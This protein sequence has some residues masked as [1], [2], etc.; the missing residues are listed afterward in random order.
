M[1]LYFSLFWFIPLGL[2]TGKKLLDKK[3]ILLLQAG[4]KQKCCKVCFVGKNIYHFSLF[5][6]HLVD[7]YV[8]P[9]LKVIFVALRGFGKF[10][11]KE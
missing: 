4:V 6:R 9:L 5:P 1:L 3:Y 7:Y 8:D 2:I 10:S 11:M